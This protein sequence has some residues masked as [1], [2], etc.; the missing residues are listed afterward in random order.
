MFNEDENG[1][2][3]DVINVAENVFTVPHTHD[4]T[5]VVTAPTCTEAGY[6]TYTCEC[7]DTYTTDEV[8]ALGH[9]DAAPEDHECDVCGLSISDCVDADKDHN[10][11]ICD[12]VMSKCSD[13]D[14]N[15][16]CDICGVQ[17]SH[18]ID[19][20]PYDHNCDWC[21]EKMSEHNFVEGTCDICGEEDPN[22]VPPHVHAHE[23]VVTAPTCTEAGYTTYT[24]ACGDTYTGD[25]VAA[26]GHTWANC[27]CT[28]CDA[29]L[30]T[31]TAIDSFD[32][33]TADGLAAAL[34]SGKLGY[35]GTFRDNGDSH[36]FAADSS[37]QFVVPANTT[38]TL[39]G[40]ST[41][42]GVFTVYVNGVKHDMAG[43][44]VFT[45]TEESKVI[46]VPDETATYSKA[47]LKG[48]ALAEYVDRT[49]TSDT[50]ITFG[51][52]GNYKD[53]L[54]DFSGIQIG[55]NGGNN[56]QVKNGS[57]DLLL[58]AGTKVVIHGYPGYTSYQLNGG[59]EITDEY[60]TYLALEDT[61][62]K[63]TP[64]N[65][66]NYFYSIE[67]TLHTGI[68]HVEAKAA[69]C[70]EAGYGAHYVCDCHG[71]LTDKGEVAALG[72]NYEAVVTAP[73]CTSVGYTTY[74]CACGDTYTGDEV[75][76]LEHEYVYGKCTVCGATDPNYVP[77]VNTL[78]VGDTN[79]IVVDG[80]TFN[81]YNLP[82]EWVAF[83]ADEKATYTFVGNN[84]ALVFIFDAE[85]NLL[86]GGT[87]TATL[88]AGTYLIC[89]GNGMVG[90]LNVAVTKTALPHEHVWSD[91]TCTEPAKCEC[92]ETQ[93]EALGHDY[94]DGL[95]TRC[96]AEDPEH[97]PVNPPVGGDDG[98][99]EGD[100]EPAGE[101]TWI[102]ALWA[103]LLKFFE[104]IAAFFKGL[105]A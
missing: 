63:V 100:G 77:Y 78:V 43:S 69:T 61:V 93:G 67:I 99:D 86:C 9:K 28:V 96:G 21:G 44:L 105:I 72:H 31:L 73:T 102:S 27:A 65:G 18:C 45:V 53:S 46:I 3:V 14:Q 60:Y 89:I 58:K 26:L 97:T 50:T 32:F 52:E 10:C 20:P 6:T 33:T 12:D 17:N 88:E 19:I 75:A 35:T 4:Y 92:G 47:Y 41:G 98:D 68:T 5:E 36:Q 34:A 24:C 103:M 1:E 56:S 2:I 57:F 23:A 81:D 74:T 95:C 82:I 25:E 16:F 71:V 40:H 76:A 64:V 11:D 8:A 22:Y 39:T 79:K 59:D 84:G 38:V 80:D 85:L 87:G 15:H 48:I 101:E 42:Y 62:L 54:V 83:V 30:P 37:I 49:I 51:S 29:V 55:D 91:A 66:N 94:A 70:T 13:D 7:G 90:E 104:W